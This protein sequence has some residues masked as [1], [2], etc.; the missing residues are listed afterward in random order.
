ML[1]DAIDGEVLDAAPALKVVANIAVGYDNI[2]VPRRAASAA[3]SSP[4]RRTC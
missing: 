2:D 3:S 4:T 1:T